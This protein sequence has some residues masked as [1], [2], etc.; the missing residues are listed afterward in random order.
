MPL[1]TGTVRI[2]YATDVMTGER[3]R[4]LIRN[5]EVVGTPIKVG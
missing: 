2:V 5:Y 4:Y 3:W 1:S